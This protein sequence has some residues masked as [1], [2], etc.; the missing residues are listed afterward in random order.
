ME[1]IHPTQPD[2]RA[3]KTVPPSGVLPAAGADGSGPPG[4][5]VSPRTAPAA[6]DPVPSIVESQAHRVAVVRQQIRIDNAAGAMVRRAM[7]WQVGLPKEAG[8][9]IKVEAARLVKVI[10]SAEPVPP[11]WAAV[12]RSCLPFLLATRE[13]RVPFDKLRANTERQM[14]SLARTLP[15]WPWVE[16]VK[17]LG[18]LGLA[19]IVGEAGDLS[20]YANPAKLW[21]RLGLA[22]FDGRSQRKATDPAEA[23]RQGYN[24]RRRSAVWTVTDSLLRQKGP[25]RDL[26]DQ[27]KAYELARA[28]DMSRMHAHRRAQRYAGKRMLRDLWAAWPRPAASLM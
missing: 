16:A 5:S 24:P 12:A 27:R 7:G 3:D 18:P 26:Y 13:A 28:P 9:R 10:H 25:Y 1:P 2:P 11:E 19:I 8:D 15:V 4:N 21:K 22:V 6:P 17:G 14:E 20:G 23:A